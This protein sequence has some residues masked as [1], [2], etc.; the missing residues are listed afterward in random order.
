MSVRG[1]DEGGRV[2]GVEMKEGGWEGWR[3]GR[4]G[5]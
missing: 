2:G 1:G 5:G 3:E 4:E